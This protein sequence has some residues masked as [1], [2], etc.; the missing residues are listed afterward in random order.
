MKL[1]CREP[2]GFVE[3]SGSDPGESTQIR[4]RVWHVTPSGRPRRSGCSPIEARL[5]TIQCDRRRAH[6]C[7]EAHRL[8]HLK[9]KE[10]PMLLI[11]I[12]AGGAGAYIVVINI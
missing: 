11:I 9:F 7:A 1:I 3:D 2:D 10:R 6:S 8:D 4:Q 5:G 12:L